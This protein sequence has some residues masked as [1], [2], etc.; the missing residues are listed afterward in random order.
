MRGVVG[1]DAEISIPTEGL[2]ELKQS[3]VLSD[4]DLAAMWIEADALGTLAGGDV[5]VDAV[6]LLT[7]LV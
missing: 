4:A 7:Y 5:V 3:G 2:L 6:H 1:A